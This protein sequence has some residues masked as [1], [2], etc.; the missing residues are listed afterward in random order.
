MAPL[1]AVFGTNSTRK[2]I[3]S[4]RFKKKYYFNCIARAINPQYRGYPRY[5]PY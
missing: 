2:A 5:H 3:N 1:A 4:A